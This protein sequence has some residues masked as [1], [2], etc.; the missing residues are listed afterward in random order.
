MFVQPIEAIRAADFGWG[1]AGALPVVLRF[2]AR[3]ANAS[4]PLPFTFSISIRNA[5]ANRSFVY[6]FTLTSTAWQV[7]TT[8][9]PGDTTGTWAVDTTGGPGIS[10]TTMCGSTFITAPGVWTAGNF[11]AGPGISNMYTVSGTGV[12]FA[13]IGLYLDPNNTGLAPPWVT[14]DYASELLACKRYWQQMFTMF[15]GNVTSSNGYYGPGSV[16]V[17]PRVVPALTGVN[18][19]NQSF[20]ATVGT[21]TFISGSVHESRVANATASGVFDSIIICNAR[22]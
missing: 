1:A 18:A 17:V 7:F 10:F 19:G 9:V 8:T 11:L 12:D 21:L 13:D 3:P 22:M 5:A 15:S 6:N 14:P 20:P 16:P 4:L 2:K